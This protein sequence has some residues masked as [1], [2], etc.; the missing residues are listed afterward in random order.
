[1][2]LKLNFSR[3]KTNST[4]DSVMHTFESIA[5]YDTDTDFEKE[6]PI[7]TQKQNLQKFLLEKSTKNKGKK[8]GIFEVRKKC[9][10]KTITIPGSEIGEENIEI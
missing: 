2:K 4:D 6:T 3:N 5:G 10:N 8:E 9:L 7:Y 1:M